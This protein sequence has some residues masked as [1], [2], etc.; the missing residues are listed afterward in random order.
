MD[1]K[2]EP[3]ILPWKRAQFETAQG[4]GI[5]YGFS[6]S[7][8][9]LATYYFSQPLITE[10]VW[11]IT[12]GNPKPNYKTVEDLRGK[13]ISIGR[14][15][16]HGI[17]FDRARDVIFRVDE[18]SSA[19][20]ARFKKLIA[21]RSD[22]ML[23]PVRQYENSQQVE[24]YINQTLIPSYNDPDLRDQYFDVSDKPMFYD[25]VHFA[26][27]KGKHQ[28]VIDKISLVIRNGIKNGEL[29][30]VLKGYH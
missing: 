23:W 2:F 29:A 6:L 25:S 13:L 20:S 10:K 21:K 27:V 11:A 18:D 1:V 19:E 4:N 22:L 5:I 17:E 26:S 28:D 8:E 16:S 3:R 15:F 24:R 30:K 9:R 12:Y 14:G 7:E